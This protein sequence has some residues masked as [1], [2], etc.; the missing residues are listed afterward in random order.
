MAALPSDAAAPGSASLVDLDRVRLERAL[1]R[2][3]RYR[4]VQPRVVDEPWGY[5]IVSPNCSRNVD[6]SG[7]EIDIARF[8][9]GRDAWVLFSRDH[10]RNEWRM[11]GRGALPMLIRLL[12][13]D[14]S[15]EF[16]P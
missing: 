16:W 15:R 7:G 13:A 10:A 4:Y 1:G 5:R 11:Q 9:R 3:S 8:E 2:R 6:A 14:P 12:A